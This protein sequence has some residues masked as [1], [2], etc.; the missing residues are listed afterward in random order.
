MKIQNIPMELKQKKQWVGWKKAKQINSARVRK[1]PMCPSTGK[2]GE[3]NNPNTWDTFENAVQA[4]QK[5]NWDGIGFVFNGD[6]VG[7]DLDHCVEDGQLNKFATQILSECNSYTEFSPSGTGIHIIARGDIKRAMKTDQIEIYNAGRYFTFTGNLVW[8]RRLIRTCD[9][10]KYFND[11]VVTESKTI[12]EKLQNMRPGNVD[13]TLTS[14]AGSLFQRG[15]TYDEVFL[16]L[17][18]KANQ[19]GHND[20]ALNRICNSVSR[21]HKQG[22]QYGYLSRG[23]ESEEIKPIEIFTPASHTQEFLASLERRKGELDLSSGFPTID[24]YTAGLKR[25]GLWTVGAYTG[26]GKTSFSASVAQHL[27]SNNKRV[28]IFSTETDWGT[29]FARFASMGT[30]IDL[31]KITDHREELTDED[32][33]RI[34]K[35]AKELESKSLYII[36]ESEPSLRIISEEISR[37][38]PDV[39]IF[40]YIQHVEETNEQRYREIGR[41]MKGM[42]NIAKQTNSAGLITS[43]LNRAA[44]IEVPALR[45]L[46]DSS[47]IEKTSNTVILL[48]R[49]SEGLQQSVVLADIAKN[50]G[51]K[52]RV[53]LILDTA[54]ASFKEK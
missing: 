13:N 15:F 2:V 16:L 28:V 10:S 53:E 33:Q 50:R 17:K 5:Y 44:E 23:P 9:L 21:Y 19:A 39:F 32:R 30:G 35:Y 36:E 24:R 26:N 3:S 54:T 7:I 14:L 25:K 27:L 22:V 1:L 51:P 52:G 6:Y 48:S 37:I 4:Y 42:E 40:D 31:H 43:Q 29:V 49:L 11:Q 8:G 38:Q 18:E 20:A 34:A 41:F 45:H 12:S 47:A 46:S